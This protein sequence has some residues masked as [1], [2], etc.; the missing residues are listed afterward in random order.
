M[1][2]IC[3]VFFTHLS[4]SVSSLV[5]AVFKY[6]AISFMSTKIHICENVCML[7]NAYPFKVLYRTCFNYHSV[8]MWFSVFCVLRKR[9]IISLI[10]LGMNGNIAIFSCFRGWTTF[11]WTNVS[12]KSF[13]KTSGC[14]YILYI[15]NVESK[16]EKVQISWSTSIRFI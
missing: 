12:I 6:T 14:G 3:G 11:S 13:A 5:H 4:L 9:D 2:V 8:N 16:I 7:N 15:S 1:S 10:G